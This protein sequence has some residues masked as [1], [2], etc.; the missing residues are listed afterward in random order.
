ML[1]PL[2]GNLENDLIPFL[3]HKGR[4]PEEQL[5]KNQAALELI[6][7]WLSEEVTEEEAKEREIYFEY[8]QEIVDSTRLP[9]HKLYSEE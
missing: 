6:R 3:K 8:F 2:D 1:E 4:T 7:G 9:G 5:Q